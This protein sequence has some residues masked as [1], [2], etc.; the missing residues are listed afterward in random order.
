MRLRPWASPIVVVVLP[1]PSGVGVIAVIRISLPSGR[2]ARRSSAESRTFALCGPKCSISPGRSPSS[3]PTSAI[4][5]SFAACAI[6]R[7]LGVVSALP[8]EVV[9]A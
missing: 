2:S 7:L 1:S 6:A 4:G 3:A 8:R 5:R 9:A